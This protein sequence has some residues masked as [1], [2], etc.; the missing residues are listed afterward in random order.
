MIKKKTLHHGGNSMLRYMVS[1]VQTKF[2]EAMNVKFVKN[3][4]A[5]KI[6]G[7]VALA[8]AIGEYMT[9]TRGSNDDRSVYEQTGI[10]YL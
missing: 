2:D 3:K 7:V 5:D 4:S 1:N 9:A 6:D 8:M 10:R